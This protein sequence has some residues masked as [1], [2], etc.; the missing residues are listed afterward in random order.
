MTLDNFQKIIPN[1]EKSNLPG[2]DSHFKLAPLMRVKLGKKLNLDNLNPKNSAVAA[3]LYPDEHN[4]LIMVFMLRKT[5]KGIHSNQI[6][7]P[8]GKVE[9]S[10]GTLL[11][12]ALRET[13]EEVGV[14]AS[15]IQIIKTLTQVYIPPSNFLVQPFLGILQEKPN[16]VLEEKEVERLIEIPLYQILDDTYL[17]TKKITNSYTNDVEVPAFQFDEDV[18]WGATAMMLSEIKDLIALQ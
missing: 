3:L 8:G 13:F 12:T 2:V 18:I 10:D 7:F 14:P 6:G 9:E 4:Q 17:N 15:A 16:F 11:T 1:I 5:Y